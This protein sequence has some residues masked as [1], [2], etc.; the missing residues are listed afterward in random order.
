MGFEHWLSSEPEEPESSS[1]TEEAVAAFEAE[2]ERH[3]KLFSDIEHLAQKLSSSLGVG[4]LTEV[5]L[6]RSMLGFM[7]EGVR[8]S[9]D[10]STTQE[11]DDLLLG[12]RLPFLLILQK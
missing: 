10:G 5:K 2:E 6:K 9:F 12:S 3:A 8:Y 7:T 4:K 1:P 11:E